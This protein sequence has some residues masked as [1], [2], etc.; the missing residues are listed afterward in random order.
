VEVRIR[1]DGRG[2]E[3]TQPATSG[4]YGLAMM[5]ERAEAAGARLSVTSQP[6]H[7]TEIIVRW[8]QPTEQEAR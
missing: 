3:S 4:H 5:R 6:G 1:D 2:F 7:G 8:Q